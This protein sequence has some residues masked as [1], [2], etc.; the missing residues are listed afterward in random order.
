MPSWGRK[1]KINRY[2]SVE[3]SDGKNVATKMGQEA[4]LES[5]TPRETSDP[6]ARGGPPFSCRANPSPPGGPAVGGPVV[7]V[8]SSLVKSSLDAKKYRL[9]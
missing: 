7:S 4:D 8:L 6:G 2:K 9:V 3:K 5:P 1:S